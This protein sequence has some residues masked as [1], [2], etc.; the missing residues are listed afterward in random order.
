MKKSKVAII[1]VHGYHNYGN[2]LQ[3][4]AV[5]KI[6]KDIGFEVETIKTKTVLFSERNSFLEKITNNKN[7]ILRKLFSKFSKIR[8]KELNNTRINRFKDF[9]KNH[10][11]ETPYFITNTDIP[12]HLSD[13]YDYFLTGSDQVWNPIIKGTDIE[14]LKFVPIKKRVSFSA[15]IGTSFIPTQRKDYYA[16]ALNEIPHIS[17]REDEAKDIIYDLTGRADVDILLDPTMVLTK[18][19]WLN[20][21]S[22]TVKGKDKYILTY[23][24]GEQTSEYNRF[25][26]NI[27]TVHNY[28]I[29]EL[30]NPKYKS[31]YLADP[32]EFVD[33]INNAELICT[34]SFHGAAFSISLNK[35]FIVFNRIEDKQ[36]SMNSR[37]TTLLNKFN[38]ENRY[39][40]ENYDNNIVFNK[41]DYKSINIILKTEKKKVIT[42]LN[43]ALVK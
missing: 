41:I 34:D 11:N 39:W 20:I 5:Q 38:L 42:F 29:I 14:F 36:P 30:L 26:K 24:L 12:E 15:S 8:Y 9:T 43:K 19:E 21:I 27:A 31:Y 17:V 35:Q 1:T 23:F 16:K 6:L 2:R 13:K 33:L 28:K 40:S 4:Y 3:N 22:T 7:N 10:I 32:S 25:I 18:K 37:I